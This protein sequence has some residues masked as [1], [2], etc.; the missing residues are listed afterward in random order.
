MRDA[1][2]DGGELKMK[3]R[4][5]LIQFSLAALI[6]LAGAGGAALAQDAPAAPANTGKVVAPVK[7]GQVIAIEGPAGAVMVLRGS[8]AYALLKDDVLFVGDRVF[9]RTNGQADLLSSG[10]KQHLSPSASIV[11]DEKFCKALP[12]SLT[13]PDP[14]SVG[15]VATGAAKSA[16]SSS[17]NLLPL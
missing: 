17:P 13:G 6:T 12:I 1:A 16:V 4:N 11:I 5:S 8:K 7:A 9:T 15:G 3:L 10:C 2:C 14:K